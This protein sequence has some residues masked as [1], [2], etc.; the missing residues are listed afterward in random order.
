LRK[1]L[2][3]LLMVLQPIALLV[4]LVATGVRTS[5]RLVRGEQARLWQLRLGNLGSGT[6]SSRSGRVLGRSLGGPFLGSFGF[7]TWNRGGSGYT[8]T[9]NGTGEKYTGG[10]SGRLYGFV[11]VLGRGGRYDFVESPLESFLLA[12][13]AGGGRAEE[14]RSG[15]VDFGDSKH[16]GRLGRGR[17]CGQTVRWR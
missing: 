16:R 14:T 17:R 13:W 7:L 12:W 1:G 9:G 4:R 10:D 2:P 5:P 15:R 8:E 6:C 11:L 3:F